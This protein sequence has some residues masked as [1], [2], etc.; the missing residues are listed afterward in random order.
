M[1]VRKLVVVSLF[2][3]G[4]MAPAQSF[5]TTNL[6][7]NGGFENGSISS[8]GT[9]LYA[10]DSTSITS[11]IVSSGQVDY[12]DNTYWNTV[13]GTRNVDLSGD[14]LS[15]TIEQTITTV[16]GATYEISFYLSGNPTTPSPASPDIKTAEVLI[17]GGLLTSFTFDTTSYSGASYTGTVAWV[18]K[19]VS[20]VATGSQTTVGFR[21]NS[22]SSPGYGALIDDVSVIQTA[23]PP[24]TYTVGGTISGLTGSGLVLT[25]ANAG[26][27][28]ISSGTSSFTLPTA[29]TS[30]ASYSVS[31]QTQPTGQTCAVSNGSGTVASANI[32]NI[33]VTCNALSTPALSVT[34][35]PQTYT[36]SA[37]AAAV[38]CS[39]GGA[40]SNVLYNGSSTVPSA[41][42]T[43]AI[44]ADCA[45]SGSYSAVTGGSAGNFV[46]SSALSSAPSAVPTLSEWAQLMLALMVIGVAWHFHNARQINC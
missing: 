7:T 35:S 34:N 19:S 40:V 24:P 13:E 30:S 3:S 31:V 39:S 46:I 44:M 42:G 32:T 22:V 45:A 15:G 41:A 25:D 28:T 38:N 37:I 17:D 26:S 27:D 16:A 20:F 1:F 29:L 21:D 5:G 23:S 33:S 14:P 8:G 12:Q 10:V 4:L 6:I 9:R 18:Q 36:G 2:I 11:W 43:Y